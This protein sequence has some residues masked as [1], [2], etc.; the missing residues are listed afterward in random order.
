MHLE[1]DEASDG[2]LVQPGVIYTEDARR[3]LGG[4]PVRRQVVE[5]VAPGVD[6]TGEPLDVSAGQPATQVHPADARRPALTYSAR[7]TCDT[8]ESVPPPFDGYRRRGAQ[9]R[10]EDDRLALDCRNRAQTRSTP[11]AIAV[12]MV[13]VTYQCRCHCKTQRGGAPNGFAP[14]TSSSYWYRNWSTF[15]RLAAVSL[16][17]RVWALLVSVGGV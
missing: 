17:F 16:T 9:S 2:E 8:R 11:P 12:A 15:T 14:S 1:R 5:V 3:P 10:S 13:P 7:S 6:L 4:D